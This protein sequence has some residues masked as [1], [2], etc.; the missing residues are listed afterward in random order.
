MP[1]AV[2]PPTIGPNGCEHEPIHIPGAIQPHGLLLVLSNPGMQ[3]I[4]ISAN[5]MQWSGLAAEALLGQPVS[6][7]I[8]DA[9]QAGLHHQLG[10]PAALERPRY[11]GVTAI[12]SQRCDV[13]AHRRGGQLILELEPQPV[14]AGMGVD[15]GWTNTIYPQVRSFVAQL[16]SCHALEPLC[17]LAAD[18]VRLMTG[19]GRVLIYRFEDDDHGCVLAESRQPDYDSYLGLHFPESDIPRQARELY[20]LNPIRLIADAHYQPVPLIPAH[21]PQTGAA[22]DL[23]LAALRSV[24]PLHLQ[25]M[26]N[27]GT[28]ASM[29]ISIIVGGRLWGLIACHH[30]QP[31]HVALPIRMACEHLGQIL[32]LQIE[33]KQDNEEAQHGRDLSRVLVRLLASMAERDSLVDGLTAM[34]NELLQLAGADGA[35]VVS[36]GRCVRIGD[37][38]TE[39]AIVDLVDWLSRQD[40]GGRYSSEHLEADYPGGAASLSP[41]AGVLAISISQLHRHYVLWFRHEIVRTVD[42]AGDPTKTGHS[43]DGAAALTP[44]SS[45]ARWRQTLHGYARRWRASEIDAADQLR[46]AILAV[47]LRRAEEMAALNEELTRSNRELEAFS[48]SVSHDL[49]A[50][51][52]HIVGYA[53]L[54]R[55]FDGERLSERGQR[56]L[57]NITEASHFAGTLVDDLLTFSQ[58]GR[59]ALRRVPVAMNDLVSSVVRDLGDEII[60]RDLQWQIGVL[61]VVVAD[62]AFLQLALRN[63]LANAVKYTRTRTP[64]VITISAEDQP[65]AWVFHVRDNG[66]GFNMKYSDK[67]FGVFQRL[68]RMEEFEGTGIGLANVRRIVERHDGRVWAHGEPDCGATFSFSLPKRSRP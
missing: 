22:T 2:A 8:D 41:A 16:P 68:H 57:S 5:A 33:A 20:R 14:D 59:A 26:R 50:P 34:P 36:S 9:L 46:H 43:Q 23:S 65:D 12:G 45:F 3:I 35:A 4:Q 63:L 10:E 64:A 47:A 31:R 58:M 15:L 30:A 38:P 13:V 28:L 66:V 25:Y 55:E 21:H 11:L 61:P 51:L 60:D 52:R 27:M 32:S 7:L 18:E 56:F 39:S 62:S 40:V 24:S 1:A 49:R 53:D 44:R 37:A 29:S 17:M 19:F 48:Y 6:V 67:L 42:W 54:L